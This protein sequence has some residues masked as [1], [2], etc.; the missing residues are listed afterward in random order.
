MTEDPTRHAGIADITER[1]KEGRRDLAKLSFGEKIARIQI[2]R[3]RLLPLKL[4]R[5]RRQS[6]NREGQT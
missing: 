5:E 3:E 1:K 2:M 4:A 6:R